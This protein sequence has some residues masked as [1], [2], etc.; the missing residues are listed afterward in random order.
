MSAPGRLS[1]VTGPGEVKPG[2]CPPLAGG[3]LGDV[4]GAELGPCKS[5]GF[6]DA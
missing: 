6:A 4:K 1:G 3:W 2:L 5:A